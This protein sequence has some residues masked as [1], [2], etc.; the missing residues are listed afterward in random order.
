[1]LSDIVI[2][3]TNFAVEWEYNIISHGNGGSAPSWNHPGDPP[4][5]C[6]YD[7]EVIALYKEHDKKELDFPAWLKD[8]VTEHLYNRDDI[9]DL[10]QQADMDRGDDRDYDY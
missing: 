1:M 9:N 5:P 10:V 8:L 6:E 7:I 2:F 3:E 4:E